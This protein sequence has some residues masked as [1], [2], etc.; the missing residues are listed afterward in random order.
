MNRTPDEACASI[1]GLFCGACPAFPQDCH[2]CLSDFVR[3]CCKNCSTHG[4]LDC[5]RSHRVTRCYQCVEFPCEKLREFSTK[6]VINGICNHADVIPDSL[7][8]KEV[9]LSRWLE[10][11]TAQ[12][13][14]PHCGR[15]IT[16]FE[17]NTHTCP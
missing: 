17:K 4:F 5:A 2:G 11:K 13:T 9:G 16:W 3:D 12:H 1:C 14:C 8:M 15:R 10:E 7:R 6:P